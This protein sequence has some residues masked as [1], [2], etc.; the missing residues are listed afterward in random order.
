[1]IASPPDRAEELRMILWYV[2]MTPE[3]YGLLLASARLEWRARMVRNALADC[4]I[5]AICVELK[6]VFMFDE[7]GGP[8]CR[9]CAGIEKR[10]GA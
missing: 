6:E 10:G 8:L 7:Y 5:C 4:E 1:M 2:R 3:T 9:D